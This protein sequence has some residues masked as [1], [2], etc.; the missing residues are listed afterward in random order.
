MPDC[1]EKSSARKTS[2]PSPPK[3]AKFAEASA[4]SGRE[5]HSAAR[6]TAKSCNH[7]VIHAEKDD[8]RQSVAPGR[9]LSA[10]VPENVERVQA[11]RNSNAVTG[12][13]ALEAPHRAVVRRSGNGTARKLV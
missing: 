8:E 13:P 5:Q 1:R 10:T 9:R 4:T 7:A 6:L 2:M 12:L 3:V 11:R